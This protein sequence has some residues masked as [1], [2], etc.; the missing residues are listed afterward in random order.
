MLSLSLRELI[1]KAE[2]Q[3]KNRPSAKSVRRLCFAAN[4][5]LLVRNALITRGRLLNPQ[6]RGGNG[7]CQAFRRCQVQRREV[8]G[9]IS[10]EESLFLQRR[11][12]LEINSCS[13]LAKRNS[14]RMSLI[15]RVTSCSQPDHRSK[16]QGSGIGVDHRISS[17][18][19]CNRIRPT[20]F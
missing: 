7:P 10:S 12:Q 19:S 16:N 3:D 18:Y 14:L 2:E 15:S 1:G 8:S 11:L 5:V 20:V 9:V 17:S 4:F 13:F 6:G